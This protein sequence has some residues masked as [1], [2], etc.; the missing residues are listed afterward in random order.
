MMEAQA[1]ERQRDRERNGGV[2][3]SIMCDVSGRGRETR[4]A[5][6]LRC[7]TGQANK[8][9]LHIKLKRAQERKRKATPRHPVTFNSLQRGSGR[10]V[11][12]GTRARSALAAAGLAKSQH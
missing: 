12:C 8:L 3:S 7:G 4:K 1:T 9:H 10:P 11:G 6:D 5:E 2:S